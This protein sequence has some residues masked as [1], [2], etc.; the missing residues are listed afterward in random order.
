MLESG[1]VP[2][3]VAQGSQGRPG[4]AFRS[5]REPV[6]IPMTFFIDFRWFGAS[7]FVL[8]TCFLHT[9]SCITFYID[10]L[11]IFDAFRVPG[12]M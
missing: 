8:F 11:L 7:I 4:A 10:F 1:I 3:R 6:R 5:S 9:F 12:V 2:P